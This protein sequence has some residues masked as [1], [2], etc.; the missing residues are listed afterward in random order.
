MVQM[1]NDALKPG[2]LVP[3]KVTRV[4][5]MLA[6]VVAREQ[7]GVI[8]GGAA[9]KLTVGQHVKVRILEVNGSNG[10]AFTGSLIG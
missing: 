5:A 3:G 7:R 8:Y 10:Y 2:D 1:G 4:Q 6:Q 9:G